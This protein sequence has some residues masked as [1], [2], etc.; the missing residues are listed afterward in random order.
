MPV[1]LGKRTA[2]LSGAI[3]IE[4]VEPL[5]AWLRETR[6]PS[7]NLRR[8]T[9]MHTA[10]LQALLAARAVVSVPP[11]E[12]FLRLWILPMFDGAQPNQDPPTDPT[13]QPTEGRS[14]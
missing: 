14:P 2:T 12:G 3:S 13:Q 10:A 4:D 7:V 9:L 8:C 11:A 6:R 1:Q 5:A